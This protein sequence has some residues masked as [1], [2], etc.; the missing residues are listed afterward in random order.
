MGYVV[1]NQLA[2]QIRHAYDQIAPVYEQH[3][4]GPLPPRIQHLAHLM[5]QQLGASAHLLDIGCG[6]GRDMAWFEHH[7][8]HI[9]GID[10]ATNM[11]RFAQQRT[12]GSLIQGSMQYLPFRS[13]S[14][15]GAW[16]C[17]S[18]LHIP[19][20][21]LPTVLQEIRRVVRQQGLV[22]IS[23]QEGDG[24]EWS[25]G[26]VDGVT[27]FFARY[28]ADELLALVQANGLS[29]IDDTREPGKRRTWL[30]LLCRT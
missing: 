26:Y 3:T 13:A 21:E 29:V 22:M 16:C 24:E 2:L 4:S 23:M 9:T 18:L 20:L 25:G 8:L 7:G 12:A 30:T 5:I 28:Q 19:K 6:T 15:D 27:R 10:L 14:F 1:M 11:L 17:A